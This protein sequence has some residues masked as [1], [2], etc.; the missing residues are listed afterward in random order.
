MPPVSCLDCMDA[1]FVMMD[2]HPRACH[3]EAGRAYE[4]N[5]GRR[6]ATVPRSELDPRTMPPGGVVLVTEARRAAAGLPP[7][8][9]GGDVLVRAT[10]EAEPLVH[11][12]VQA[13]DDL[14]RDAPDAATRAIT[15]IGELPEWALP[16]GMEEQEPLSEQVRGQGE[17]IGAEETKRPSPP[18]RQRKGRASEA[19]PAAPLEPP[20]G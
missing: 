15:L 17:L 3:C 12:L 7:G 6:L 4:Q 11:S 13:I 1:G 14:L 16:E 9:L 19:N 5:G 2:G 10:I 8:V 20:A 18:Q